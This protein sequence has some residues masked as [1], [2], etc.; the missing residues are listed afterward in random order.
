M[1]TRPLERALPYLLVAP[2]LLYIFVILILPILIEVY[3]SFLTREQGT[4]TFRIVH[5][6]TL[7]NYIQV[8][9]QRYIVESLTFTIGI[10]FV[11]AVGTVVLG[12]PV[13]QFLARGTGRG[14]I[15]IEMCLLLP[16]FGDIFT[17]YALLYAFAP[18]G[19]VNWF[20][21]GIGLIQEPLHLVNQP[22]SAVIA[23]MLPSLSVLLMRGALV[24]VDPVYEEAAQMLGA[25]PLR[26]WY[27]TTF[28]LARVGVAGA[29]LL[30]FIG[31]T[32]AF[33][34][35]VIM[36]NANN[37][38]ISTQ[39]RSLF[40][41]KQR[42]A[43]FLPEHRAH[44]ADGT[45]GLHLYPPHETRARMSSNMW[46]SRWTVLVGRRLLQIYSIAAALVLAYPTLQL[47]IV[48]ASDDIVFPPRYFSLDAFNPAKLPALLEWMPF[49]IALG[50]ATTGVLLAL[51]IPMCYATQRMHFRG[52]ALASAAVF[53]PVIIPGVG[54]MVALGTAY[55]LVFPDLIGSFAGVLLPTVVFNLVWMVR[56]I[57]SSLSVTDPAYE[58]AALMLGAS[59]VRAF[60][61]IT[62]PA[63]MPGI[64]VGSMVTFANATTA[65]TAPFFLG[66]P[67]PSRPR[68]GSSTSSAGTA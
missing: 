37:D 57:Q 59:R 32:G 60:F 41:G 67:R 51:A 10:S 15:L 14:K 13:A 16:L 30:T 42:P 9:T 53:L 6:F 55:I 11:I 43:G 3:Y 18:Q 26:A 38:W 61:T 50:L 5:R 7:D 28:K 39:L 63:I 17:A 40:M 27:A 23:M 68:W 35:P 25:N 64:A 66:A 49:S 34:L 21:M 8:F 56:A 36:V 24:R 58:D 44:A 65:F 52:K 1:A 20:L 19:I 2:V 31:A 48:A 33:T 54:Y 62:L 46:G 4:Y 45:P 22:I 12:M 47:F 29:F